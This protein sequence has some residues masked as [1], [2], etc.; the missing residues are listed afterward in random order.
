MRRGKLGERRENRAEKEGKGK[1]KESLE[2]R[3]GDREE[4]TSRVG[5]NTRK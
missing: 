2:G 3:N 1:K 4:D 5:I